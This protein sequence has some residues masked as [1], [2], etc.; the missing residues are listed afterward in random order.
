VHRTLLCKVSL[1]FLIITL[2][3]ICG[4]IC[5][6]TL[7]M[8]IF[9]YDFKRIR[10][11]IIDPH[12]YTH[13]LSHTH[14]YMYTCIRST[15][16]SISLLEQVILM[17]A[18]K[19]D[20]VKFGDQAATNLVLF[21]SMF[22]ENMIHLTPSCFPPSPPSSSSSS[23]SPIP[24]KSER[25]RVFALNQLLF[26]S[27]DVYF[28]HQLHIKHGVL[29]PVLVHNNFLIGKQLKIQRFQKHN[30]W[31]LSDKNWLNERINT[32]D[33]EDDDDDD[34]KCHLMLKRLP[35]IHS[36]SKCSFLS[37]VINEGSSSSSS[38]SPSTSS[39]LGSGETSEDR[40]RCGEMHEN[41][42]FTHPYNGKSTGS[43]RSNIPA[44]RRVMFVISAGERNWF[45]ILQRRAML[46]AA[47]CNS[48]LFL[49]R[50]VT[51][52]TGV[53]ANTCA[54]QVKLRAAKDLLER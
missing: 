44:E 23:S 3:D 24:C 16:G 50:T 41:R 52:H 45:S 36:L 32:D 30:L 13:A 34:T 21:E 25:L 28:D 42:W 1:C 10:P 38:S 39:S 8:H 7:Y 17:M 6:Y 2:Y 29:H 11:R 53:N 31:Y 14:T 15:V 49:I 51:C 43:T 20:D 19:A 12:T 46:Y 27:G 48:D 54:K 35:Y 18:L 40:K 37:E 22:R 5:I 9:V 4:Y 26:P 33:E 47:K